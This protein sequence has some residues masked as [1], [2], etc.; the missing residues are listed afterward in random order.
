VAVPTWNGKAY[1]VEVDDKDSVGLVNFHGV[2]KYLA[3]PKLRA[4]LER[5]V[6]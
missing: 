6:Q 1:P 4:E 5:H 2:V 3:S